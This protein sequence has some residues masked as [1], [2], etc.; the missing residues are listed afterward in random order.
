MV[1]GRIAA[2]DSPAGLKE[3]LAARDM[4][5]VFRIVAGRAVREE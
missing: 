2:M 1:D 3:S 5:E 4:D